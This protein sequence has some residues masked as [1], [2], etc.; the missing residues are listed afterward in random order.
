MLPRLALALRLLVVAFLALSPVV[1][2][3]QGTSFISGRVLDASG[4]P[5]TGARVTVQGNNVK[6]T[7]TSDASGHFA[8]SGLGVGAYAVRAETKDGFGAAQVEL[9]STGMEL[10]LTLSRVIVLVRTSSLPSVHGSGTD[11]SLNEQY[12]ARSPAGRDFGSVLL[13]LPGAARGAN[14]VVHINGDHGDI[15]Y[16]VDGVPIPQELNRQVGSE[17]DT[18]DASYVEVLEGAYPA[19]YGERFGAIVTVGTRAGSGLPGAEGYLTS[20]SYGRVDSSLGYHGM[21]A[22]GSF[23]ANVRAER[24]DRFLDPPNPDSPH[25]HGSNVNEFFRYT[26]SH[27]SD[28]WNLTL[29]NATH[30]IQIP[31][32]VLSGEPP[33]TDD[34]ERQADFFGALQFHHAL[35]SGGALTYG[36]GYKRSRI[37]DFPDES[38]DF[39]FG[40]NLNLANGGNAADCASGTVSACAYSLFADR[41]ARDLR[42]TIDTDVRST[43]HDVRYGADYLAT[44]VQKMYDVTL[45]PGNFLAPVLTPLTPGVATTVTDNAPNI[46]HTTVAYLQDA[47][48]LG[49][50]YQLDY[51][52]RSDVFGVFSN[53]F[54]R[55][56]SQLSPRVKLTRLY[57]NHA[58]AYAYYGRFFTP[59][60]LENVSP[61]AAQL[62][63]LPNQPT[64]AQFDLKPQRDS[65]YEIGGHLPLG[66][67]QLGVRIMQK[68][69]TDLIDDT[70]VGVTALHQDIN[71]AQ[72]RISMQSAYYQQNLARGGRFYLSLTHG[73]S[74]N[75][76]CETHLLAPCFGAPTDWTPADHDQRWESSSGIL[77]NDQRGGWLAIEGEFGSGLSSAICSPSMLFCKVPPHT[78]FDL[79][80]G[81]AVRPG[82]AITARIGNLFNDRYRVTFQNAQGNHYAQPRTIELGMQ[83]GPKQ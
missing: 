41:T 52:V 48:K 12:L 40:E 10:A 27:A 74:L 79:E 43:V 3:A 47:W 63:N 38:N 30:A 60:S 35:R 1:A 20:G 65:V 49:S 23:V 67:G 64:R 19:Q 50:R 70:Q 83:F 14:G 4:R 58:S 36:L 76:G 42:L 81:V 75:K 44:T 21:V 71:Y 31:N 56:Y 34:N 7:Q 33:T 16:V 78:T 32:D 18:S 68:N 73:R 72:G 26:R 82:V 6:L 45:Q 69:A 13:Q 46:G 17:F 77:L 8:F 57:G 59:F 53:E 9:T 61:S 28:Y 39:T 37:A 2:Y 55:T 62:L 5:V 54:Q 15:N 29:S 51:G 80:K 66:P 22:G 25:N 24:S 11:L